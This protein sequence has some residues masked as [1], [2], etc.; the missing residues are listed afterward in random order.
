MKEFNT[1][2]VCIPSKHY[3][4]DL[5][6][7]VKQIKSMVDS[8]KYFTI[9]RARQY[10]K[11]TT[12]SALDHA[13]SESYYVVSMDFQDYGEESFHDADS[14]CR[15]F[16]NDFCSLLKERIGHNN[17]ALEAAIWHVIEMTENDDKKLRL[18]T[19]FK[20]IR[21]IWDSTDKPIV[22]FID[23][24]DSAANNQLFIDFLAALRSHY[25]KREKDS[26]YRT[27]HSVIL[28]GVTDVKHLK[29]KIKGET[30]AS[31]SDT[32]ARENSPWNIAADFTIDMSLSEAG[33]KGMLDEYE[34]DH[35][36]GMDTSA[37]AR[38]IRD[39]TN[40]YPFLV[41]RICQII[42]QGM[43]SAP[44]ESL[45]DSWTA[46]GVEGAVKNIIT[47][48]NT[49]FDSLMGKVK[50]YD[51]LR[52]QLKQ[53]LFNGET[54]AYLPDNKEQEQLIMY[55]LIVNDHNTIAVANRIFEMRL[56]NY[57]IGES[58]FT[59]ELRGD[60]IDNKPE[61]IK[62]GELNIPLIMERFI[63]TQEYIRNLNDEEA[64]KRFI[65]DE[66]REKFL[67]YLSPIINGVGT[68]SVEERNRD[69]RRLDVVIHYKGKRYIIE[70]KIWRGDRYNARGEKQIIDY[71]DS[72]G[73]DTGYLLSFNFNK[74][75][76]PGVEEVHI[77]EKTIYEGIV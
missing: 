77:G 27:F 38:Q 5:T 14:F 9:N 74:T 50:N 39:Y 23:E 11:T 53:I 65:E 21:N 67:T 70:M 25:L 75:K 17:K 66:G 63:R 16:A 69:R 6:E 68:F 49:L 8:G 76:K 19:T 56:Y 52:S 20:E 22:L 3:M 59:E 64:E 12:L 71:L 47:E 45:R 72:Y 10:G 41:S 30:D 2:A 4:V 7:T 18:F 73:L 29:S 51:K 24:V 28:A 35:Q 44:F 57:F 26:K 54:I 15:D 62:D 36:T 61:F 58:R 31:G 46:S 37:I 32:I 60:A 34:A 55:G 48:K 33:I 42:D 13:L 43:L 40:G 1:T